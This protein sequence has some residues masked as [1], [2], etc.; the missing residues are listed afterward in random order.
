MILVNFNA[1][2]DL[3]FAAEYD[4]LFF[5]NITV[6]DPSGLIV[7]LSLSTEIEFFQ[8]IEQDK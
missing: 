6:D 7:A 4:G 1:N 5:H 3:D 2:G 8:V